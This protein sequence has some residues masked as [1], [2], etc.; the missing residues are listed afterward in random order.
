MN[1]LFLVFTIIVFSTMEV[2]GRFFHHEIGPFL[3]TCIRFFLGTII[4]L[5]F[6]I[7]KRDNLIKLKNIGA[8]E[9]TFIML[10]GIIN[11]FFSMGALQIAVHNGNASIPAILI[12]SNPIFIYL[13]IS[14]K[15]KSF[16]KDTLI[17]MICGIIGIIGIIAFPT[18]S[19]FK[20]PL[21][22]FSFSFIASILFAL[23]TI[24]ARNFVRK[25]GLL[26]VTFLSFVAGTICYIPFIFIFNEH[27][28]IQ[29]SLNGILLLLYM[30]IVI[31]GAGYLS[32]FKG[33]KAISVEKGSMVF[34]LKPI[35]AVIL[36]ITFLNESINIIQVFSIILVLYAVS[37]V[38]KRKIKSADN[39]EK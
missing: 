16:N 23:Y 17:K 15:K 1:Y 18:H 22:A 36:S 39:T 38:I 3:M 13:M 6:F 8:K 26:F 25:H 27:T 2:A 19:D 4:M 11:V 32:Y 14:I 28:S 30:G 24:L 33:L 37:P 7:A 29:L 5:P 9:I 35:F 34:F 12:S 10:T 20:N 21:I 31:T